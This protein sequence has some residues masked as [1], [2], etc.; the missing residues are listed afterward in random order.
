[1]RYDENGM[2]RRLLAAIPLLYK[3]TLPLTFHLDKQNDP[4]VTPRLAW[5]RVIEPP[6][7]IHMEQPK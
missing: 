6:V 3:D 7:L 5:G 4:D 1:M 2:G